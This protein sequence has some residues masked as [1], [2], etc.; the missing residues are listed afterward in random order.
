MNS[1]STVEVQC[2]CDIPAAE[3]T[4]TKETASKGRRFWTCGNNNTCQF[5]EWMDGPSSAPVASSSRQPP[6]VAPAKRTYTD[7]S[8]SIFL[9]WMTDI[10]LQTHCPIQRQEAAPDAGSSRQC[11]CEESAVQRTVLK[12]GPNIGRLFWVCPKPQGT[13]A[14]C[15]Y[16]EWDDEPQRKASA[17]GDARQGGGPCYKVLGPIS[18][19]SNAC[20]LIYMCEQCNQ[21]GHWASGEC[22]S[23]AMGLHY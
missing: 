20:G 11:K 21:E 19:I 7:H 3:R 23:P 4:V 1:R 14:R 8:V 13:D 12:E 2:R 22:Y 18:C 17:K 5:F 6:P 10:Q 16:F 9:F 15:D